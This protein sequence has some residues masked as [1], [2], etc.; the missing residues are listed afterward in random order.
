MQ[1]HRG[2][3]IRFGIFEADTSSGELRKGGHPIRLQEQPFRLLML[4]LQHPGEVVTRDELRD[5]LWG[6][7]HVDFEDGLNTA[8]RKLRDALGDSAAN[9]RFIE[10][11]PR[12]GYRFIAPAQ[13]EEESG[14]DAPA[15]RGSPHRG[16]WYAAAGLAAL[17]LTAALFL[18]RGRLIQ[19]PAPFDLSPPVQL[20][21][22]SGLTTDPAISRDGRLLAYASD[23]GGTGN[24]D[25]WVQHMA[26][27]E[28]RRLAGHPADDREPDIS[29]DASEVIFRSERDGG[30]IYVVPT[31]GGAAR[32]LIPGGYVPRY[33]PD[34]SRVAYGDGSV[35]SGGFWGKLF[36]YS[37]TAGSSQRLA[38]NALIA[39]PV[40][41]SP[42]GEF[43]A[44]AGAKHWTETPSLWICSAHGGDA[45]QLSTTRISG[46]QSFGGRVRT[47]STAWFGEQII[48]SAQQG[49]SWNLWAAPISSLTRRLDGDLR[50]ITLGSGNEVLPAVSADGKVVF[51]S[52][53]YSTDI[54]AA[55]LVDGVTAT[56]M[57]RLTQDHA[58]DYRPSLSSDGSKMAYISNRTGNFDVWL[59]DLALGTEM[60]ITRTSKP[61]GF[62]A[63]SRDG[64][65]IAFGDGSDISLATVRGGKA[66]LLCKAC[67]RPDDW[68]AQGKLIG[69]YGSARNSEGIAEWDPVS[70]TPTLLIGRF[71][72]STGQP[73]PFD[74]MLAVAPH[75]SRDGRWIVFHT[76][77]HA[78]RQVQVAPY[79]GAAIPQSSWMAATDNRALDRE[80]RWSPAG[81]L[82]YFLS[83]RDG[84]RCI[85]A[86][87]LNPVSKQPVGSIFP[88]LHLHNPRLSLMHVPD[89]G[90]VSMC[91]VG[92][93]LIFTLGEL[94]GN[95]WSAELRPRQAA[96]R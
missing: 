93:K 5:K 32:P 24:L 49:D 2:R 79:A 74:R 84:F 21:R 55:T 50:R 78:N 85:W 69:R 39:G 82:I 83:D 90:H 71:G 7:T 13:V 53:N 73:P 23:R 91:A 48:V 59:K 44:F 20:T 28:A 81:D 17:P 94:T 6:N 37:L 64:E 61:E 43:V 29:P 1:S 56:R 80:A 38:P 66:R 35:G 96:L 88:V 95:L 31:L 12:R 65:Q 34:G 77:D 18:A 27:G 52:H 9:P 46:G 41:W 67:G 58:V 42:D 45:R 4:L 68:S 62:A 22:D 11:L 10:T 19:Q 25:L 30:G 8:V 36:V 51:A 57:D 92:D 86:R 3:T 40:A 63:I 87:R 15:R 14:S 26:G 76:T 70:G 47:I 60:Q 16:K 75:L 54:W 33:S 89:T 72:G